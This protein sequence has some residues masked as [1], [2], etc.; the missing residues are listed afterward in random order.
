VKVG[1]GILG[2]EGASSFTGGLDINGGVIFTNAGSNL[3][4]GPVTLSSGGR[5]TVSNSIIPHA[6]GTVAGLTGVQGN[7]GIGTNNIAE[8]TGS[9]NHLSQGVLA[10]VGTGI[11]IATFGNITQ[12]TGSSLLIKDGTLRFGN[13]YNASSLFAQSGSG[14]NTI[15]NNGNLDTAGFAT[16]INNL[17]FGGGA[18]LTSSG[19][20]NVIINNDNAHSDLTG[21]QISATTNIDQLTINAAG[22]LSLAS[23]QLINWSALDIIELNG[24]TAAN[25]L[26]GSGL[27]DQINGLDGADTLNGNGGIDTIDGGAGNDRIV[28]VTGNSGSI[29]TGGSGTDTLEVASGN[30]SLAG[31][32]GI[33]I[34]QLNGT[35]LT[36]TGSQV[37]NGLPL[38]AK[39]TGSGELII[40]AS[41]GVQL[42]T[43]IFDFS[44]YSLQNGRV[45]INGTGGTDIMKLGFARNFVSLGSGADQI[46][47]GDYSDN[48]DG[49]DG[50]DKIAGNGG[51]DIMTGG[52]GN[53][54]FKFR[55]ASDSGLIDL[56]TMNSNADVI[57]D[58]TLGQDRLNFVNID[59]NAALAGDQAF[60]FI[61]TAGFHASGSG[62]IRYFTSS[63]LNV[64][65]VEVDVDGNGTADMHIVLN[66]LG[67]SSLTAADLVL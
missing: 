3:G 8:F 30:I 51:L 41:S 49:G 9:L 2:L 12:T 5:L 6:I 57:T 20:L 27:A 26:T 46:Q 59:A 4:T 52:A 7:G 11:T 19:A 36:L 15:Q 65:V 50:N 64:M 67:L 28:L 13:H 60:A 10:F 37:A 48:I 40:N 55:K 47:G 54:V 53:D 23:L 34:L 45:T 18:I 33:E 66:Q 24:S 35:F 22:D 61:G 17:A 43:K 62:E 14:S 38:A 58:F 1:P 16:I 32:S 31:L 29:I 21:G 63:F 44:G 25:V 42:L 39:V 56:V